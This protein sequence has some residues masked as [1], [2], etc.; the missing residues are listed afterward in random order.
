MFI[1]LSLLIGLSFLLPAAV[2]AKSIPFSIASKDRLTQLTGQIDL[3]DSSGSKSFPLI[4]LVG[5]THLFDR[6][7]DFGNSNTDSDLLFRE[8]S[9]KL[10]SKGFAVARYDYR[11]IKCN[12][13]TAKAC[14]GCKSHEEFMAYFVKT[15]IDNSIRRT[16]TVQ[17]T[18][19]DIETVYNFAKSQTFIKSHQIYIIA[20][21]EGTLHVAHLV[22]EKRLDPKAILFWGFVSES[23]K[24]MFKWQWTDRSLTSLLQSYGLKRGDNLTNEL[25]SAQCEKL[26]IPDVQCKDMM[27]PKGYFT[28]HELSEQI[29]AQYEIL[30]SEALSHAESEPF[31]YVWSQYGAVFSTYNWWQMWFLDQVPN[32][33]SLLNYRGK[34]S[35][36][37]GTIDMAT[38]ADRE[39]SMVEAMRQRFK[40]KIRIHKVPGV[41]HGLG[42]NPASGPILEDSMSLLLSEVEWLAR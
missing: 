40:S 38:P 24:D 34:I 23:P 6:D 10:T 30:R 26:K 29:D 32:I 25:I 41:G 9:Q 11:G 39:L 35:F 4:L 13:R 15:C 20:H 18:R 31:H 5:G 27:S 21:S 1:G 12:K 37:N 19:D 22:N 17:T 42:P 3:P 2:V 36:V 14:P 28:S 16:V 8:L 7:Y 33:E